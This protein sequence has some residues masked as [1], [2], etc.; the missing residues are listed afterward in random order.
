MCYSKAES[1]SKLSVRDLDDV[2]VGRVY[3]L[4]TL[5]QI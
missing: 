1:T 4:E 2:T 3:G 5:R